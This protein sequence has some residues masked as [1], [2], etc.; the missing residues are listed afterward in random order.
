MNALVITDFDNRFLA[1]VAEMAR[2]LAIWFSVGWHHLNCAA[3]LGL[4]SR[5]FPTATSER[6]QDQ[7]SSIL[8]HA[9]HG[10]DSNSCCQCQEVR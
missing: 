5:S 4:P 3:A 6:Q 9:V 8:R 7:I 10:G 2:N 1:D